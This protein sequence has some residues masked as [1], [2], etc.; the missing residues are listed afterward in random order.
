MPADGPL[1]RLRSGCFITLFLHIDLGFLGCSNFWMKAAGFA[2]FKRYFVERF[3][4][5]VK[6]GYLG[7]EGGMKWI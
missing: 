1:D 3:C 4:G 2:L 6:G 5:V 7:V